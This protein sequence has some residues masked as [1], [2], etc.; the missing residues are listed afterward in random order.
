MRP[1]STSVLEVAGDMPRAF[2]PMSFDGHVSEA[3][4]ESWIVANPQLVGEPLLVL[5]RQLAEF[6]EDQDRLDVLAVDEDGELVLVELKV[7]DNFRVT[8]LQ[9]IAYAG[10]YASR[11]P[12]DLAQT[13]RRTMQK[14]ADTAVVKTNAPESEQ[15]VHQPSTP[16]APPDT[17]VTAESAA[18]VS[19]PQEA[20]QI[21]LDDSQQ[22]IVEFLEIDEFDAWQPSQHVRI[23][24]VAPTF[25]RRVLKTVKWLG[26]VYN[27]P[28]EVIAVRLFSQ[29]EDRYSLTFARLLP[30]PD[31]GEFDMTV[32]RREE[33]KRSEN[34][35][36][37]P[38][39]VPVLVREGLLKHGQRLWVNKS[40][41]RPKDRPLYDPDSRVFQ[42][43]VRVDGGTAPKFAWCPDETHQ[44]EFLSPSAVPHRVYQAVTDWEGDPF[45]HPVAG[46]FTV[47][48]EGKT[49]EELA[50]EN[51][52][53]SSPEES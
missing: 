3:Q 15:Q 11:D 44:P 37:R 12:N 40:V 4:L 29:G 36:R 25:P 43:E 7:A 48:P 38:A 13:L 2:T 33:R 14:Q 6:E 35:T 19:D 47:A 17:T 23:R 50:T 42:V 18:L 46:S 22:R 1:F 28:I 39:L 5:G 30:L 24:L 41:L 32:R 45:Y 26:D 8:D 21:T 51:S 34:I 52:L 9:A 10:A 49:L 16:T 31:E 20:A 53:W 27:M